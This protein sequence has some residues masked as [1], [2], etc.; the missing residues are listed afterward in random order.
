MASYKV[1]YNATYGGF[2]LSDLAISLLKERR[3]DDPYD[4]P[5]HHPELVAVVDLLSKNSHG[6]RFSNLK[7]AVVEGPYIIHDYDGLETVLQP[8]DMDWINPEKY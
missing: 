2:S 1:V 7:I 3:I 4:L 5:R 6:G 8:R